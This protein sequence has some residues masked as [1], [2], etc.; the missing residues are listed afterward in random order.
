MS[1][2]DNAPGM[3]VNGSGRGIDEI[4]G[5]PAAGGAIGQFRQHV[6]EADVAIAL[7]ESVQQI[8]ETRLQRSVHGTTGAAA[9][10][11]R[12]GAGRRG[13]GA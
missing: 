2:P 3:P 9:R 4:P 10:T 6:I 5:R 11:G 12:G 8:L 13:I 7:A 1:K